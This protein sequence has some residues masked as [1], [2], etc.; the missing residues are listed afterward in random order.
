MAG[1]L[2]GI[3]VVDISAVISGPM[4]ALVLGDQ[5]ADVIKVEPIGIGDITR[6]GG[7][8]RDGISAMFATAN[9]GKRCVALNLSDER[10]KQILRELVADADVF[11]Q[12][13]RPGAVERMGIGPDDLRAINPDL[14]YVSISGFGPEGPYS[15]WRV[16]DPVIQAVS[17]VVSV[18]HSQDIP[19]PDLIR[20]LVCD[21]ATALTAAQA[22]TAAL[23]ARAT[24]KAAG[25][26]LVIPMLDTTLYH[27][28]PDTYM[29]H[30]LRGPDIIPGPTLYQVYRLQP[31]ADGHLVY[32]AASD[33][34]AHGLFRAL[35]RSDL[36]D[37]ARFTT[38]AERSR[39]ENFVALGGI[40]NDE[41]LNCTTED[42]MHRLHAEQVPAAQVNSL[43]DVFVDPQVVHNDIIHTFE[44]DVVGPVTMAKPPVRWSSTIPTTSWRIDRLG[45][46]TDEVLNEL[47][48]DEQSV[49]ALRAAGVI[50]G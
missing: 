5:G 9:R 34:E 22:V 31:T 36:I 27:L 28:W 7:F 41:F 15:D 35:G 38:M 13:F 26:H 46:S 47:G 8:R 25:Q 19:I 49:A 29:A 43:D 18:Q 2:E 17:G 32:F 24:G 44:H 50:N 20:T 4:C 3:K 48:Y 1:P 42:I 11:I 6:M 40:L 45:E 23:F 12:N 39:P 30:T 10:G 21:K 33:S 16:Y 37:D 14:I